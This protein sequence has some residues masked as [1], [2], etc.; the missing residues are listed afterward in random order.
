[1]IERPFFQLRLA[2]V[3]IIGCV[4]IVIYIS[5]QLTIRGPEFSLTTTMLSN[6]LAAL[7][8]FACEAVLWGILYVTLPCSPLR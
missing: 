6:D 2:E 3:T 4:L 1:M 5:P 8:G 7:I